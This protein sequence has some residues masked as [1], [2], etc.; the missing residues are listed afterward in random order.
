MLQ[1][2]DSNAERTFD[3][4]LP[5]T[6]DESEISLEAV[7]H[8]PSEGRSVILIDVGPMQYWSYT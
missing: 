8:L 1:L 6:I 7:A 5:N 2:E 4:M 3:R